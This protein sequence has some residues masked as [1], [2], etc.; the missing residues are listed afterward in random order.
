[1]AIAIGSMM[2]RNRFM[3]PD[4]SKDDAVIVFGVWIVDPSRLGRPSF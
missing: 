1:M 4:Q 3:A 2:R